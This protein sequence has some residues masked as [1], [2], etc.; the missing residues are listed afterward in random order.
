MNGLIRYQ[1]MPGFNEQNNVVIANIEITV[2]LNGR[3]N[4]NALHRASGNQEEKAPAK[5]IRNKGTQE[6][7]AE[8]EKETG[9]ICTVSL[10][11]RNGGT[12]AHELLA[13]S[14]A[15]WISPAFQL[16]VNQAFIDSRKPKEPALPKTLAE[17]LRLAA[18]LAEE[19]ERISIELDNAIATKA[20]IGTR[21]EATAMATASAAVRKVN[22]LQK[23]LDQ[24]KQYFS[25]KRMSMLHHGMNFNWRLLKSTGIEMGIEPI[26][27]FDQNYGTVKAYHVDVWKEAYAIEVQQNREFH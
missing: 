16:K 6:L 9:Q 27:V 17:A 14:Y 24:S 26:D 5:W 8:L 25:I 15:G 11:G 18:E 1:D 4:L 7:I 19:R 23:E 10:E 2:D 20:E 22:K 3:Y 21:R 13:I 12:F